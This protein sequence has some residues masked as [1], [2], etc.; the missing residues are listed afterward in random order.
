MLEK[1]SIW[2]KSDSLILSYLIQKSIPS[3]LMFINKKKKYTKFLEE[4]T[5]N[6][7]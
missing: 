7:F 5:V 6:I 3:G 2:E 4:N 1:L